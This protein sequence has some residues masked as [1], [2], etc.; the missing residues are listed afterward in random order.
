MKNATIGITP[1]RFSRRIKSSISYGIFNAGITFFSKSP[2]AL[3]CLEEWCRECI[4]CCSA[5][6]TEKSYTDQKYLNK[7][8]DK[9]SGLKII[10]NQGVNA[11]PWN[12]HRASLVHED[13]GWR[14]SGKKMCLY[15]F[16]GLREIAPDGFYHGLATYKTFMTKELRIGI[17]QPYIELINTAR[18]LLGASR[19]AT[20]LPLHSGS[21]STQ[22]GAYETTLFAANEATALLDYLSYQVYSKTTPVE[23]LCNKAGSF[24][25]QLKKL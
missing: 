9:Y 20:L 22:I 25:R 7:W 4:D 6:L 10:H 18:K 2:E 14:I 13:D 1:H 15:H 21:A 12:I 8:P 19:M 5:E 16:H 11:A 3:R 17:Y 23:V 24:Y